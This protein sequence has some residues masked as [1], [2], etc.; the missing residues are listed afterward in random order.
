MISAY[1][2]SMPRP[3]QITCTLTT[4]LSPQEI[5][6]IILDTTKWP[7]FTGYGILPGIRSAEYIVKTPEILGSRIAVINTDNST[8]IEEII[9]WDMPNTF[10]MRLANFSRPLSFMATQFVET[11]EFRVESNQTHITRSMALYPRFLLTRPI[12]WLIRPLLRKALI[13]SHDT[14]L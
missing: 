4:P 9:K 6:D 7:L 1:N 5:A 13:R 11:F 10:Q 14:I 3:L 2:A 8:H 12:L